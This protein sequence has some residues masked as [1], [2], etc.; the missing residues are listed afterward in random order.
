[1]L[2]PADLLLLDEPTNDLDISTLEVLEESLIEFPGALVLVTH[3]RL[4]M[5]RV[6]TLLLGLGSDSGPTFFADVAQWQSMLSTTPARKSA[7]R[8]DTRSG[9]RRQTTRSGLSY[10]EK[11]EYEQIEETIISAEK[12]LAAAAQ[13]LDDPAVASNAERAHEAFLAHQKARE[14]VDALYQRWSYLESR[15]ET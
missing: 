14:R 9:R 13:L 6:A 8:S 1:M 12:E 11:K 5:D 4:L 10:L 7:A 2:R 15:A 3:D